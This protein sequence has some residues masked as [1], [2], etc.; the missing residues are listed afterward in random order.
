MKK[1]LIVVLLVAVLSMAAVL[2]AQAKSPMRAVTRLEFDLNPPNAGYTV[3]PD[4]AIAMTD[5]EFEGLTMLYMI[6]SNL[7]YN[8]MAKFDTIQFEFAGRRYDFNKEATLHRLYIEFLP[9]WILDK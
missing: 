4:E 1:T 2:F 8:R 3:E 5:E 6:I 7:D 9:A